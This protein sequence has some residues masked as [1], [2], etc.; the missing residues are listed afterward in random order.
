MHRLRGGVSM[1]GRHTAPTEPVDATNVFKIDYRRNTS[2]FTVSTYDEDAKQYL[3]R[4]IRDMR[5]PPYA[6]DEYWEAVA[7]NVIQ[8]LYLWYDA[9]LAAQLKADGR[10]E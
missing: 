3:A 5:L 7:A 10:A 8:A 4:R 9:K 2:E 1:T 6:V